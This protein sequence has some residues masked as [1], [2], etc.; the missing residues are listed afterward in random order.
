M[1]KLRKAKGVL[2]GVKSDNAAAAQVGSEMSSLDN[3]I[4]VLSS[5]CTE[6]EEKVN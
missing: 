6:L 2:L 1:Q 3:E 4:E 5:I